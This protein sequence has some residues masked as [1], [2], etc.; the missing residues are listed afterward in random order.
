MTTKENLQ[1]DGLYQHWQAEHRT[2]NQSITA[3]SEWIALQSQLRT[4]QYT[5]TVAKLNELNSQLQDHFSGEE[6]L[7]NQ[8]C[9]SS[10]HVSPEADAVRRQNDRDHTDIT[11][12]LKHLIDRMH[13]ASAEQDAWKS[14]VYELGLIIDLVEQ[15]EE[16]ES[17]SVCCLLPRQYLQP[18]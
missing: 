13:E 8:I 4:A 3:L 12:R 18:K 10:C 16:Q 9:E 2:L 17:E 11:N 1:V 7:S 6:A 5:E 15:H 14:G